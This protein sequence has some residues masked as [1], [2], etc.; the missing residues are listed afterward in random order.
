MSAGASIAVPIPR[1]GR[2]RPS[3]S[4][5][6]GVL[7]CLVALLAASGGGLAGRA[8]V[9]SLGLVAAA[10]CRSG[11][12]R[13]R[14]REPRPELP[15]LI[16]PRAASTARNPAQKLRLRFSAAGAGVSVSAGNLRLALQTVGRG[17]DCAATRRSQAAR[18]GDPEPGRLPRRRGVGVVCEQSARPRAGIHPPPPSGRPAASWRSPSAWEVLL[19]LRRCPARPGDLLRLA[20]LPRPRRDRRARPHALPAR[21]RLVEGR[22]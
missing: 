9:R 14:G 19:P 20:R 10:V 4:V 11:A 1:F 5:P 8:A 16:L 7:V 15:D 13:S 6:C 21:V 17:A 2:V 3:R 22:L 18:R 12:T